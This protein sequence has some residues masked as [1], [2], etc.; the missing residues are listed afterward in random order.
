MSVHLSV[1][2]RETLD[3][4]E[5]RPGQTWLDGTLGGGGH[6]RLLAERVAPHGRVIALDA[7]A[8]PIARAAE[9]LRNLPVILRQANFRRLG[10]VLDELEIP[11]VD[12]ILLD[13]GLSSDQLAAA[14]RGFSFAAEGPLDMR[15]DMSR[16]ES[17]AEVL[18]TIEEREL[19][20]LIFKYGEE[21]YSRRIAKAIVERRRERPFETARDLADLIR[22]V[23]PR[24]KSQGIDPA[25][26]TFQA[27]RIYVN[28][29]LGA[30]ETALDV[31][32]RR[33][34]L[35]GRIGV[36][37]FHS[38]EDRIVKT[39]FR[40][41]PQYDSLTKKPVT[42]AE[43]ELAANPRSR[44]AKLR[45]ARRKRVG[46][47]KRIVSG[48][49]TGVD[50]GGLD[51][52]RDLGLELGGWC[53]RGRIAEDGVV[54]LDYPL[55]ETDSPQYLVRT[56]KNVE[57]SDA[58]LIVGRGEPTGGTARTKQL[59]A[60]HDKRLFFYD[61]LNE[62]PP[63]NVLEWLRVHKIETL[64]IAGPRESNMPGIQAETRRLL[65]RL[66]RQIL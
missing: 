17:A 28:D 11:A 41:F 40:D 37:S 5:P 35:N 30:L 50:R 23:I 53:P 51:A 66:L 32:R 36:I 21:H 19:A 27:L 3:R 38:L 46:P 1:L 54:P 42:A 22:R 4:L 26:R 31:A 62:P 48:G 33:L 29:E 64:N 34:K 43:D 20:D 57:D 25:T 56:E 14:E 63:G 52:G 2:P 18:A 7:D 12:G 60:K 15:F 8:G 44:S 59:A 45:V 16:D 47:L 13:I 49:Q 24:G 58:T 39:A 61:L 9:T 65:A 55:R 6:T 10:E